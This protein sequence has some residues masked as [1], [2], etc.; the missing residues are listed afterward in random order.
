MIYYMAYGYKIYQGSKRLDPKGCLPLVVV[1]AQK[2]GN[3]AFTEHFVFTGLNE[4]PL[5]FRAT[6]YGIGR[7]ITQED[8]QKIVT[9]DHL[10]GGEFEYA[11]AHF[12]NIIFEKHKELHGRLFLDGQKFDYAEVGDPAL[13]HLAITKKYSKEVSH[14]L[15]ETKSQALENLEP[16]LRL[17]SKLEIT[18]L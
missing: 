16:I 14:M 13:I 5:L 6:G 1:V 11:K 9:I 3:T 15:D 2:T 8:F 17:L 7:N 4:M 18:V 12:E 10:I